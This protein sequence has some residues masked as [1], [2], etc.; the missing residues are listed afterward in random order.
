MILLRQLIS[1]EKTEKILQVYSG[2]VV[3]K[4]VEPY[5]VMAGNPARK[6]KGF[7]EL[8]CGAGFYGKPFQW[9]EE[10]S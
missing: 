9:W 5:S 1:W 8:E 7:D 2:S 3:V 4:D 10:K 6:I